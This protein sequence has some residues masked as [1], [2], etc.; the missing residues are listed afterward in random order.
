VDGVV[1]DGHGIM[2]E[3][4][5]TG[6]PYEIS[7][8]PGSLAISGAV[9]G[10][11]ALVSRAEKLAEDS[12]YARIMKVMYETEQQKAAIAPAGRPTGRVVHANCPWVSRLQQRC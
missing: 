5:L 6:E 2:D 7:K 4:Y 10:E 11:K 3:A 8:T 9:S 1:L 12:R